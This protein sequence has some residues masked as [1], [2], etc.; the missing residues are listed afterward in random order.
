MKQEPSAHLAN[1]LSVWLHVGG[2]GSCCLCLRTVSRLSRLK[3]LDQG[4]SF[5]V[6]ATW[7]LRPQQ[8]AFHTL[9]HRNSAVSLAL[10]TALQPFCDFTASHSTRLKSGGLLGY[11]DSTVLT[12]ST[13]DHHSLFS[14]KKVF[15]YWED[16]KLTVTECFPNL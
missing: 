16:V 1:L 3:P 15:K 8:W 10:W 14:S 4:G 7:K 11:A 5:K 12:N 13:Y 6:P 9:R 2:G